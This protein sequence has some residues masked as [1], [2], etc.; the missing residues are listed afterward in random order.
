[1][2]RTAVIGASG[3]MGKLIIKNILNSKDLTLSGALEI[4]SAPAI[5]KDAG[6]ISGCSETG[7]NITDNINDIISCSDVFID[8]STGSVIENAKQILKQNKGLVIGTTG[9]SQEIK[10]HLNE[11]NKKNNG[12]I[13]LA[14]NMSV[15]VNLLFH[16]TKMVTEVLSNDYEV[17]IVEMHH[18]Q[19]KDAPS[20]TA[21]R[22]A[23]V[24]A[25][26]RDVNLSEQARYGREGITGARTKEEIG[27]HVLRGGDVVGDHT[28]IFAT[29]GERIELTHKASSKEAFVKGALEA[30]RFLKSAKP[31]LYDM[32]DVLNIH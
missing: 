8:F 30:A 21:M 14:P 20:G 13:V 27:I 17:E 3:R 11:L 31:G 6:F 18:N 26:T 4:S 29:E 9:L 1:M 23:E 24:V 19:K 2:I 32:Q 7:I 16:I 5:G 22:L 10:S 12:R 25:E 15:G 28:V